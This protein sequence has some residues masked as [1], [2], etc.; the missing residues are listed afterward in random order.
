[1]KEGKGVGFTNLDWF[2]K[3]GFLEEAGLT[4]PL[5]GLCIHQVGREGPETNLYIEFTYYN[6]WIDLL[7]HL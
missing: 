5:T 1:M 3:F 6:L 4:P 2:H 7:I